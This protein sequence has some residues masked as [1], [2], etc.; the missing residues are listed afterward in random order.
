LPLGLI[1]GLDVYYAALDASLAR[2]D[3]LRLTE[4]TQRADQPVFRR[5]RPAAA[6]RAERLPHDWTPPSARASGEAPGA[7]AG[8]DDEYGFIG[9]YIGL[10]ADDRFAYAAWSDMRALA[11]APDA[12]G[13]QACAGQRNLNVYFARIPRTATGLAPPDRLGAVGLDP[14]GTPR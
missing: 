6:A 4:Q 13:G 11:P 2:I 5:P 1:H 8:C 14:A 12:C 10:A 7:G 3:V 9:D